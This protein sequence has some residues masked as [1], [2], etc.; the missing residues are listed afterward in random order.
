MSTVS[1]ALVHPAMSTLTLHPRCVLGG[2]DGLAMREVLKHPS[3]EQV[4]LVDLDPKMPS[5]SESSRR[6][7][8]KAMPSRSARASRHETRC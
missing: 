6:S 1:R 7:A 2:G 3:V 5:P 8:T 4:T